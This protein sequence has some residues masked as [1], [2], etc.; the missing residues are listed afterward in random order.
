MSLA[1]SK[2][3][4]A[5]L[6]AQENISVQHKKTS[7]AYFDPKNRILVLPIWKEMSGDLYDLLVG[8]EVGHAWE[9]PP[10]GWHDAVRG[11]SRG[12]KSYLNVIEDA[13][14]EKCIKVR[15]PG[16]RS[17]FYKA[18][19]DLVDKD[20]FGIKDLDVNTLPFIDRINLH[21]K[22]GPFMAVP[23]SEEEKVYIKRIDSLTTWDE[24]LTIAKELYNNQKAIDEDEEKI[25]KR[26]KL[27]I[28]GVIED[29]DGEFSDDFDIESDE[30]SDEFDEDEIDGKT[31]EPGSRRAGANKSSDPSS[32]TD[33]E[34]RSRE[35]DLLSNDVRP[36]KYFNLPD[37]YMEEI[38]IPHE[39]LYK[40]TDWSP[41]DLNE[42]TKDA[43]KLLANYKQ[44][45]S[46]FIQYLVKEFELKRN[47]SQFARAKV[48]KTGELN[49]DKIFS[50]KFNDDLFQRVTKI[51]GGKNHG[52]VMFIDWSG[53]MSDNITQTI[54]QTLVL[55]DFCKK[56][57]IPFRVF[58]FTDSGGGVIMDYKK[59]KYGPEYWSKKTKNFSAKPI[60]LALSRNGYASFELLSNNM[61]SAQYNFAQKKLLQFGAI[62]SKSRYSRMGDVP[63]GWEL[64]STPL[65]EAIV[66]ANH[67]V[68][69]FKETYKLD[70]VNTIFLTDGDG[71]FTDQ[72]ITTDG[73]QQNANTYYGLRYRELA[74]IIVTDPRTKISGHAKPGQSITAALLDLLRNRT[75]TNLVG[76]FIMPT[77]SKKVVQRVLDISGL[78][79][80]EDT[81]NIINKIRKDK[82]YSLSTYAYDKYFLVSANDLVINDEEMTVTTDT[83]KRDL[84]KAFIKN[85]QSKLMNRILLNKFIEEIA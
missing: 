75:G 47:A 83:S 28:N 53:S 6:L 14:I 27:R 18:Y 69:M 71:N 70:I 74:N 39:F 34:F 65:N 67:F 21:F 9:T 85:R 58:S 20:F 72:I 41:V 46:K 15:Y 11:H 63:D 54:E 35:A 52:M 1:N 73:N 60:D 29:F 37:A 7:T 50:Y 57:N 81:H 55:A 31:G 82:F 48:A 64:N 43:S 51:P 25:E 32:I 5:K 61:T 62:Y 79:H 10:D 36:Y 78:T 44:T 16:L 33:Q 3:T 12:F 45:N 80:Q 40:N 77:A 19:K 66:F 2:S 76:Y 68:P 8:H 17:S 23:F 84:M 26:K 24:V 59:Y 30:D 4:L 13:R 42:R 49:L 56:V 38:V 22:V